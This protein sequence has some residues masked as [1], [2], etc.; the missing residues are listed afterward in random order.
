[1][2]VLIQEIRVAMS[3]LDQ[4]IDQTNNKQQALSRTKTIDEAGVKRKFW[5]ELRSVYISCSCVPIHSI[6]EKNPHLRL[7]SANQS[8][9]FGAKRRLLQ[10]G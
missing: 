2:N 3:E 4:P 10:V 7:R 9:S 6:Q 5:S 1:M 8:A